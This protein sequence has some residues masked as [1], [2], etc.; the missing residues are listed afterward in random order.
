MQVPR[1]AHEVKLL[2][3]SE[4]SGMRSIDGDRRFAEASLFE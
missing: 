1:S 3:T 4:A 2:A